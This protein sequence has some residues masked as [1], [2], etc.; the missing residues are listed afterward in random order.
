MGGKVLDIDQ[1]TKYAEELRELRDLNDSLENQNKELQQ[2]L[3]DL[4]GEYMELRYH[5]KNTVSQE[6]VLAL[7]KKILELQNA[8]RLKTNTPEG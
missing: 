3:N 1:L 5:L 2:R 8:L 7:R 6:E 4:H